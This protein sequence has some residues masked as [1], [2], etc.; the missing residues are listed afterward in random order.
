MLRDNDVDCGVINLTLCLVMY[1]SLLHQTKVQR[2][3]TTQT[4]TSQ[5][6]KRDEGTTLLQNHLLLEG[7]LFF[8]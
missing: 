6:R 3:T 5:D 8:E 7:P 4:P 1:E 2:K